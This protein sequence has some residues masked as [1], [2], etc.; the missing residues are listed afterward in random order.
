MTLTPQRAFARLAV[1]VRA[2][3]PGVFDLPGGEVQD[4][5]RPGIFARQNVGRIAV[6]P[7]N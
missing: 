4:M 1:R 6:L 7:A 5:Y 3:T 2:V